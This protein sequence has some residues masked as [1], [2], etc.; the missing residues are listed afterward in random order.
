M[1]IFIATFLITFGVLLIRS[2]K[3]AKNQDV[4]APK[5]AP[6]QKME[7][8]K[9]PGNQGSTS[10]KG[11]SGG[12]VTNIEIGDKYIFARVG[13]T[14]DIDC[15]V[16][17]KSENGVYYFGD[18]SYY[19]SENSDSVDCI[20]LFTK[21]EMLYRKS[22]EDG[23]ECASVFDDGTVVLYDD[24]SVLRIYD[25]EGKQVVK[26]TIGLSADLVDMNSERALFYGTDDDGNQQLAL[27]TYADK[28]LTMNAVPDL[29]IIDEEGE[30]DTIFGSDA[31]LHIVPGGFIIVY[32]ND[33]YIFIDA[34][35]NK[36]L[37]PEEMDS[38]LMKLI[39]K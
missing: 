30:E 4:A 36:K 39:H 1:K 19:A 24:E 28:K 31:V 34:D 20:F 12:G 29:D 25:A 7:S 37:L 35:G 23:I 6:V 9:E 26:K 13:K 10:Q 2:R 15:N 32:P 17:C 22:F 38:E 27:F 3:K 14:G 11:K 33:D 21:N 16:I 8:R 5:P 18:G